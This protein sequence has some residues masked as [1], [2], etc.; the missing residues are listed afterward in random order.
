VRHHRRHILRL[1]GVCAAGLVSPRAFAQAYPSKPTQVFITTAPGGSSDVSTRLVATV[2]AEKLGQPFVIENRPGA[3]GNIAAD[4]VF[5]A[6]ADGYS[7]LSISKGNLLANLFYDNLAFDFGKEFVALAGIATGPLLMLVHPSV[8]ANTLPEFIAYAK[9]NPTKVN[10]ATPGIG[11]DPHLTVEWMK[12]LTGM[13][14]PHVPYR[15]GALALTDLLA[16]NVQLMFSN[17]PA[18]QYL[19]EGKLKAL[20]VTS[21]TRAADYPELPP[22]A[23]VLPGFE[24]MGWYAL[25]VRRGTPQDII[26]KINAS[27]DVALTDAKVK[28]GIAALTAVPMPIK[29]APLQVM[30]AAEVEKWGKVI[31]A[32]NIKPE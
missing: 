24:S 18:A 32:A 27:V 16:G 22:V 17:L 12:M 30:F 23:D 1:A 13:T 4:A 14:I 3:G 28:S 11:S 29:P 2:L 31:K 7:I 8:P 6:P 21:L 25:A 15:G 10:Y 20:A 19:K 5:R 9:A 26:D